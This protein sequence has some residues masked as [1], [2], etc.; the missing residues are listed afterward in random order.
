MIDVNSNINKVIASNKKIINVSVYYNQDNNV[1]LVNLMPGSVITREFII[2]NNNSDEIN[3]HVTWNGVNSNWYDVHPEEL[4]YE[5]SCSNGE[6]LERTNMPKD[7]GIF[8]N[9]MK[10]GTN[11]TNTCLMTITF[12]DTPDGQEYNL[13][14]TFMGI[15]KVEIE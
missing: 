6:K 4:V 9:N 7:S 15:F 12:I 10:L 3:Y 14:R 2:T 1:G 5:V 13:N 8:M 11:K